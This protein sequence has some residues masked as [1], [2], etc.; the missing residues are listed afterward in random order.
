MR[1]E[2]QKLK[3]TA[4]KFYLRFRYCALLPPVSIRSVRPAW[5]WQCAAKNPPRNRQNHG[6]ICSRSVCGI[7]KSNNFFARKKFKPAF[8]CGRRQCLQFHLH[9]EQKHQ[10]V[11]L[12]LIAVFADDS[13][14]VQIGR[15]AVSS[16][17]L[18]AL[19]GTRRRR[20]IRRCPSS[21][22]RRTG[23]RSRGSV[24]AC[25]RAAGFHRAH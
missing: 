22:C 20:A 5:Q 7:F 15:R 17:F 25:V 21:A 19:R 1:N 6:Q 2:K 10:P 8:A 13:G 14:Q 9:L 11:R 23:S 12:A 3:P 24:P 18:R 16:R 4:L